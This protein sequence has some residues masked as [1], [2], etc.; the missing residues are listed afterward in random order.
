[1]PSIRSLFIEPSSNA[2][3]ASARIAGRTIPSRGAVAQGGEPVR[4]RV[5]AGRAVVAQADAGPP[6][7]AGG[8]AVRDGQAVQRRPIRRPSSARRSTGC[9]RRPR[10]RSGAATGHAWPATTAQWALL[11]S[12]RRESGSSSRASAPHCRKIACGRCRGDQRQDGAL[13]Q[14]AQLAV[15]QAGRHRQ[16]A[17]LAA[18]AVAGRPGARPAPG[19]VHADGQHARV[20]GEGVL[21]AV[22]VMRI[23][24]EIDDAASAPGPARPG[25][26]ARGR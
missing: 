22:A 3:A 14:H 15:V 23:D 6:A 12:D 19:L 1:M 24:V 8:S 21:H 16:V 18:G 11:D 20:V 2:W 13:Q 17:R 26:P 10:S 7:A 4:R 9:S 25:C 5:A